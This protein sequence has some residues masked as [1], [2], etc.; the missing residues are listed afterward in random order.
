MLE[1]PVQQGDA[2]L[3]YLAKALVD[4]ADHVIPAVHKIVNWDYDDSDLGPIV[5]RSQSD[6]QPAEE[7]PQTG[8]MVHWGRNDML[9]AMENGHADVVQWLFEHTPQANDTRNL[10]RV[11]R[12]AVNR[13]DVQLVEWLLQRD[14]PY[15]SLT[16]ANTGRPHVVQWMLE[17][18]DLKDGSVAIAA[19]MSLA[20]GGHLELMQRVLPLCTCDPIPGSEWEDYW[21]SFFDETCQYGH[22]P[23]VRW[24]LEQPLGSE[25]LLEHFP[26]A[27]HDAATDGHLELARYLH[28]Q[29]FTA[30]SE[31]TMF[32][33]AANGHLDVVKWLR[34]AFPGI[35]FF[36]KPLIPHIASVPLFSAM[37]IAAYNGHLNVLQ[38]LHDL[39]V[40]ME[41]DMLRKRKRRRET[42]EERDGRRPW[43]TH[44]AMDGAAERGH[45]EVAQWLHMN[46]RE[47]CTTDAID[48]AAAHGFL[49]VVQWLYTTFFEGCSVFV[50]NK[51]A[52]GG[53]LE[54]VQ[55]VH[56]NTTA[57]CSPDAMDDCSVTELA[58]VSTN[59]KA[60]QWLRARI[61]TETP[62]ATIKWN[63]LPWQ[64]FDMLLFLHWHYV[65]A[66]TSEAVDT[67]R[68]LVSPPIDSW[69]EEHY[70]ISRKEGGAR[71]KL[72][73][74]VIVGTCFANVNWA[75]ACSYTRAIALF[76]EAPVPPLLE[77]EP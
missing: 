34:V 29:G 76:V 22:L 68:S 46:R 62:A 23:V 61:L 16:A 15:M 38:Y 10:N 7:D 52:A 59:R 28:A 44:K 40:S 72:D 53:Y 43:A 64:S 55:W 49:R 4:V 65:G 25:L 12:C 9:S 50:M 58:M 24:I 42:D 39:D 75:L 21:P 5:P 71:R 51:A 67:I 70:P 19:V 69:L 30:C 74:E 54:T 26:D 47:G 1:S 37:D 11:V 48:Q 20:L 27:M 35:E 56:A 32:L 73:L 41:G 17:R 66:F 6:H 18:G 3:G 14:C 63:S 60:L 33:A 8:I 13:G 77:F 2:L 45:L 36:R 57:Q 31:K